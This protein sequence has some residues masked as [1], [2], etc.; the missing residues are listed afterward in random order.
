LRSNLLGGTNQYRLE[1]QSTNNYWTKWL[2]KRKKLSESLEWFCRSKAMLRKFKQ[3]W[4]TTRLQSRLRT[5]RLG[6]APPEKKKTC[7][8]AKRFRRVP[9]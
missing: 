3:R 4:K 6:E 7:G 1:T 2:N 9:M 8:E 5:C